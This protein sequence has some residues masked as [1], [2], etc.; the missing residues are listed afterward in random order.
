MS[1]RRVRKL[2]P[3]QALIE[4]PQPLI[5]VGVGDGSERAGMTAC[6]AAQVSWRPPY[7][8]IAIYHRWTTLKLLLERKEFAVNLVSEKLTKAALEVFGKLSS[9]EV[10]KFRLA[11]ERYGL[12]VV[13]GRSVKAPVLKDAPIVMECRL[14]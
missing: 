5:I 10:D 2:T 14:L 12:K 11:E 8:G 6:W 4:L 13:E 1:E 7:L 3:M 9:K